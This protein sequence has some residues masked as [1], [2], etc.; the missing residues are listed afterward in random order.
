MKKIKKFSKAFTLIELLLAVFVLEI[1]LLG[2][3]GFYA[4]SLQVTKIAR[5]ET[6][7]SNLAAGVIDEEMA[8]AYGSL[9]P[10]AKD[11]YSNDSNNAFYN[12]YRE[13]EISCIN[14]N[15]D[16]P[17]TCDSNAHMKKILVTIYWQE[18]QIFQ[19]ATI[20]AEH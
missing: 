6:I 20:K 19:V 12:W 16:P 13:V 3:A 8:I 14:E 10:L 17:I 18:Q 4:N 11:R 9:T 15:L 5:N 2:I 7:A 1:G